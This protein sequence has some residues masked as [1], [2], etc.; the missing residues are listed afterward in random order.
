[1]TGGILLAG[2]Q[3]SVVRA[4]LDR[5]D[6]HRAGSVTGWIVLTLIVATTAGLV[7]WLVTRRGAAAPR[8]A[9][10]GPSM[11]LPAGQRLVWLS[12]TSN[13]WLHGI[14][15]VTGLVAI[16]AALA[17][18]CG[19][20]D[21]QWPLI[22]PLTLA[23]VLVLGCASV[24]ARVSE[25]GLDVSFGPFGWPT[26]HWAA[27][28]IESARAEHRTPAQVGGWGYRLSGLGTT[29]MLRGGECLVIR[30]KGKDFALSV[31]DAER[32]AALLNSLRAERSK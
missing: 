21:L 1:M 5:T 20:T 32:G 26:R 2:G 27:E 13:W 22:T 15:A 19:L 31:D 16:A 17:A 18:A 11:D 7:A 8:A 3:A 14:S 29:V 23:S 12:R 4:N 10:D 24:Q 9:T 28:E 6:W 30:A 25:R